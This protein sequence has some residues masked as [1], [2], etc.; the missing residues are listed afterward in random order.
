[1]C[2]LLLVGCGFVLLGLY[3][4]FKFGF[5]VLEFRLVWSPELFR[6]VIVYLFEILYYCLVCFYDLCVIFRDLF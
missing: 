4:V 6:L 2:F 3:A 5:T 1:M